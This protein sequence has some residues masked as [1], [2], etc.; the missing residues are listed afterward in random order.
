MEIIIAGLIII[1]ILLL[2]AVSNMN[3]KLVRYEDWTIE[4]RKQIYKMFNTIKV[5]DNK[6]MFEK[7]D[8]VGRLWEAIKETVD[9]I[10]AFVVPDGVEDEEE[11]EELIIE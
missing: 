9:K 7:D 8:D 3:K 4:M 6:Q 10:D 1:V 11:D 2:I 5:L